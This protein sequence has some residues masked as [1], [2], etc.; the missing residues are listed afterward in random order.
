MWFS[1]LLA[2]ALAAP[3]FADTRYEVVRDWP[4][5]PAGRTLGLCAGVG[6]DSRENVFVF[7]RNDRVWQTSFP[8]E[9]IAAAT[10]ADFDGRSG[11]LL[12]EWGAGETWPG[13]DSPQP[14]ASVKMLDA[15]LVVAAEV[16]PKSK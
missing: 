11:R 8:D 3:A 14:Q 1:F 4:A 10:V 15:L 16:A 13:T 7:H 9:P 6:V 2:F 5:L 12:A